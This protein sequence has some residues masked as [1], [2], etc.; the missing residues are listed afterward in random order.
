VELFGGEEFPRTGVQMLFARG[1]DLIAE[2]ARLGIEI[3]EISEGAPGEEI[4]LDKM[5]RPLDARRAVGIALLVRPEDEAETL[6]KGRHLGRRHHP[7][8]RAGGDHDVGV[9]NHARRGRARQVLKRVGQEDLAGKTREGGITLEEEHPRVAQDE[10][11]GLDALLDPADRRAMGRG[12]VLHLLPDREVVLADGRRWRMADPM[13][14]A[15][16][17]E[18]R[19]GDRDTLRDQLLVDANEIAAAAIDPLQDLL[20]VGGRLLGAVNPWHRRAARF[21]HGPHRATGDLQGAGNL[22][23]PVAFCP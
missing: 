10:R 8:A 23:G 11:R 5:E 13:A 22:A 2:G 3:G 1:V 19:V 14:P 4:V 17:R 20:A 16:R 18:R 15:K 12:I 7:R 9:I 6:G 21:E